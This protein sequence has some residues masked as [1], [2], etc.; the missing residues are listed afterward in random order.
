M[1]NLSSRSLSVSEYALWQKGL[2]FAPPP[3]RVPTAHIVAAVECGLRGVL[4]ENAELPR[5][6]IVGAIAKAR[7]PPV[8]LLPQERKAIKTLQE[9]DHILVLPADNGRAGCPLSAP[10][11]RTRRGS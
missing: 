1:V 7:P 5:T 9:D 6:K 10:L 8:N 3:S 2:N 11:H 4:E